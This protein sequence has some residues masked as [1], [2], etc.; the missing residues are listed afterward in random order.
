MV[1]NV[2]QYR[3]LKC[4]VAICD[5]C[6]GMDHDG[7]PVRNLR[8]HLLDVIEKKMCSSPYTELESFVTD[9]EQLIERCDT[10]IKR[11]NSE[12]LDVKEI[13]NK[14]EID[15][16][17]V[18]LY[19]DTFKKEATKSKPNLAALLEISTIN[20]TQC[21]K[22][23]N[24]QFQ[25]LQ[26]TQKEITSRS[27]KTDKSTQTSVQKPPNV[28]QSGVIRNQQEQYGYNQGT[29]LNWYR[30][31]RMSIEQRIPLQVGPIHTFLFGNFL[32]ELS[33]YSQVPAPHEDIPAR[34]TDPFLHVKVK[35][36]LF[37][38][39]NVNLQIRYCKITLLNQHDAEKDCESRNY[40]VYYP[41]PCEIVWVSLNQGAFLSGRSSWVTSENQFD[42]GLDLQYI[43]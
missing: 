33:A 20:F 11:L 27:V 16:S 38:G 31:F 34:W 42:I 2:G 21:A 10:Q 41:F 28:S 17:K 23:D 13:M 32:I 1:I 15:K 40:A 37:S 18:R 8:K 43:R 6:F 3:C 24:P 25:H 35:F 7:H 36:H 5:D 19:L 4:D 22:L 14:A 29:F 26:L 39:S 9:L 12:T 30:Y